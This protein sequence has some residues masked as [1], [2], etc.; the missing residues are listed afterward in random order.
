MKTR[1]IIVR[2]AEAEGN[3]KRIFQGWTDGEITERGHAQAE[4]VAERL[5][6][7]QIDV[8][9]SSSM[10]RTLQTASYIAKINNLPIIRT[11]KLKEINGGSW[12]GEKWD[13]LSLKWPDE[14]ET[15]ENKPHAHIMPNGESM[16]ELQKRLIDEIE[17]IIDKH[18]GKAICIVTH[19][20]AIRSLM[21]R[22][23]HCKL[24]KMLTIPWQDNTSVT[25][26]DYENGKFHVVLE[27]DS[28]HLGR[29]LSTVEN[30]DWWVEFQEKYV[31]Q[32][33]DKNG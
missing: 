11:D 26:I 15:W 2:H 4:R 31:N 21:C 18:S 1:L 30:Q 10:K 27:G 24:E 17:K 14:Y 8:L 33:G 5:K 23:H 13:N 32:E 6:D 20:T 3:V 25:I 9:Y 16:E 7:M 19:G 29:D 22:F 12:E 28:S